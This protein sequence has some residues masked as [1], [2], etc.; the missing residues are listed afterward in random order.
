MHRLLLGVSPTGGNVLPW[1]HLLG[2]C[3]HID[4]SGPPPNTALGPETSSMNLG[5]GPLGSVPPDSLEGVVGENTSPQRA[6]L[7]S[8]KPSEPGGGC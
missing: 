7:K 1:C 4:P 2:A 5:S 3:R 8:A 6:R